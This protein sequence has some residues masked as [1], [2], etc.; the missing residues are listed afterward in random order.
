M[1]LDHEGAYTQA[2]SH[3]IAEKSSNTYKSSLPI[4]S[5]GAENEV[6]NVNAAVN[7]KGSC[8]FCGATG[9]NIQQC[10]LHCK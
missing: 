5:L 10:Y 7:P 2:R 9:H 3:E 6:C 4:T 1:T 8:Y